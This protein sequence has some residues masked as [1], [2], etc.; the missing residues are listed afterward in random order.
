M[1]LLIDMCLP[2]L[3]M[4]GLSAH[5]H[6]VVHWSIVGDPSASDPFIMEWARRNDRTVITHDLDF[7]DLLFNS[8]ARGPSV[9]IIREKDTHPSVI[10]HPLLQV[11]HQCSEEIRDGVLIAMTIHKARIRRLPL[12]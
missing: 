11:L 7:G 10:L 2:P 4:D 9:V 5:G 6:D 1:R 8:K 12:E 3:L